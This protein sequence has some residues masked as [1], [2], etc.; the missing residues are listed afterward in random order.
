MKAM[1]ASNAFESAR[2]EQQRAF[3]DPAS[4]RLLRVRTHERVFVRQ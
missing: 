3:G 1:P 2:T 4:N